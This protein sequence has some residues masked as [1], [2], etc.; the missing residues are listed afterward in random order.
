[1]FLGFIQD[2]WDPP[3]H[4]DC[5]LDFC[6]GGGQDSSDF[7]DINVFGQL[8]LMHLASEKTSPQCQIL[9]PAV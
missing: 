6:I 3:P 1:M 5:S 2:K 8:L 9:P 7:L 4:P